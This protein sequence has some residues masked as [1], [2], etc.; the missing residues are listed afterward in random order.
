M[1]R[2][3]LRRP[4]AV[5]PAD[6]TSLFLDFDGT[7]VRLV[8]RPDAVVVDPVLIALL[9]RLASRLSGRLALLSGRSIA[10]LDAMLGGMDI[11]MAGSHGGEIRRCGMAAVSVPRPQ[12]LAIVETEI[13]DAFR[14]MKGVIVEVKTLGVAVHYRL[15]PPA[16]PAVHDIAARLGARHG[17][18]VQT[19][20]MIVE[21]RT[22]GH[23][24]GTALAAMMQDPPFA[25]HKP[26]FL[27]DDVTDEDGF[28]ACAG[29]GGA[30]ILVGPDRQSAARYR[31]DDVADVHQWLATL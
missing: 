10:Q 18:D 5:I 19:G 9:Q 15:D 22:T 26:I 16:A 31:L 24:K 8:E 1:P 11:A 12:T 17:L 13:V 28:V 14:D 27:G 30:G 7:L 3:P 29:L 6:E 21:L 4:P 20:K 23:D 2:L 25:G